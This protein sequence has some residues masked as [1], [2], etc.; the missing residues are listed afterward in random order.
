MGDDWVEQVKSMQKLLQA[1]EEIQQMMQVTGEEGVTLDDYITYHKAICL[2]QVYLQQD[3]FDPVD[4]STSVER[5][6]TL[7]INLLD[8]L[9][10]PREFS[11][12]EKVRAHF[13]KLTGLFR[14]LNYSR[15]HSPDYRKY[16]DE[17]KTM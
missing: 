3:A 9:T 15:L 12:K 7:F 1:G 5:Q 17:I 6:K 4:A 2:D 10:T 8:C 16:E 13:T 11:S 14:N